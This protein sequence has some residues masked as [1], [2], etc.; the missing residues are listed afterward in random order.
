MLV[1]A[2]H[3]NLWDYRF[4]Q[5]LL[6][7]RAYA[8]QVNANVDCLG[9]DVVARSTFIAVDRVFRHSYSADSAFFTVIRRLNVRANHAQRLADRAADL[10]DLLLAV[11]T[12]RSDWAD[13]LAKQAVHVL[14]V[15][16]VKPV[17]VYF[18]VVTETAFDDFPAR[19]A[20]RKCV[21]VIVFASVYCR[22]SVLYVHKRLF[23]FQFSSPL[24][25]N[26]VVT[27]KA[28]ILK[29]WICYFICLVV[30]LLL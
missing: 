7:N 2:L 30:E 24:V 8:V 1:G 12:V 14:C 5:I 29:V 26:E 6:A 20:D 25:V 22:E 13:P 3:R 10:R 9:F 11:L 27:D 19:G 18:V 23:S 15:D 17:V 16:S 4:L 21:P 28:K